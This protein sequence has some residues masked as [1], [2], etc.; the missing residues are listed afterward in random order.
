VQGASS[1][2]PSGTRSHGERDLLE[3]IWETSAD[4]IALSDPEGR[5]TLAN[6][7]YFRLFGH[8]PEAVI[9]RSFALIFPPDRRAA[10]EEQYRAAFTAARPLTAFET[11]VQV[12]DGTERVVEA[13]IDF[14][15]DGDGRRT[16]MVNTIRDV[17]ERALAQ[18]AE[19]AA[20]SERARLA[21]RIREQAA[22]EFVATVS[23]DLKG[24]LT[25]IIGFAQLLVRAAADP[26]AQAERMGAAAREVDAQARAMSR[27]IDGLLD[28]SRVQAG[29]FG[30]RTAPCALPD[31]L[32]RVLARLSPG[33][34]ARVEVALDDAPLAGDWDC[35]RVEQVLANLVGN[36]LK[37]SPADSPVRVRVIRAED[38]VAVSVADEGLGLDEEEL[39]R[40]FGRFYRA[41]GAI[42]SGLPGTGLGLYVCRGI[43]E[44]HGG[45]I[46]CSSPGPGRGATF[47]FFLPVAGPDDSRGRADRE[48]TA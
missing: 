10:A 48:Q 22:E 31:C 27:L 4:A 21:D 34:R 29:A 11:S 38:A 1:A 23:H 6:P 30:L 26:V 18:E 16:A 40:V 8:A 2:S 37:Y 13:R 33:E 24:P 12:A 41:P 47:R 45:R 28:A 7:A 5:V 35:D 20:Q 39:P 46:E 32:D 19:R 43:V 42:A 14:L 17:T 36:A 15:T 3:A 44:A 25:A 9:G